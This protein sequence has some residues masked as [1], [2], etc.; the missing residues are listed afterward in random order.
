[1]YYKLFVILYIALDHTKKEVTRRDRT[2][3][4]T[5]RRTFRRSDDDK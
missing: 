4:F 2:A 5:G 1:M 3:A